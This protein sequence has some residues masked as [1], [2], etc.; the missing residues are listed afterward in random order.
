MGGFVCMDTERHLCE[1]FYKR[2]WQVVR[3][4]K[5]R[6]PS[7]CLDRFRGTACRSGCPKRGKP[8]D[9]ISFFQFLRFRELWGQINV[10]P[11]QKVRFSFLFSSQENEKNEKWSDVGSHVHLQVKRER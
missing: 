8:Y 1:P 9:V 11:Q 5:E 3:Q 10:E 4:P 2:A 7:V 6:F